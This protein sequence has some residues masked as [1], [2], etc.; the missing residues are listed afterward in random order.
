MRPWPVTSLALADTLVSEGRAMIEQLAPLGRQAASAILA[1]AAGRQLSEQETTQALQA[2]GG[3]P[4]LLTQSGASL[5]SSSGHLGWTG[6][7]A[8][9]LVSRFGGLSSS[10][11]HVTQAASVLG[12]RFRP[13]LVTKVA[14]VD[15]GEAEEA[16]VALVSAGLVLELDDG[17]AEFVHPLFAQALYDDVAEPTR[18][19]MHLLAMRAL[20][21][22]GADP[23]QAAT[24]ARAGHL[25][26]DPEAISVLEAAG[27]AALAV[28][29]VESALINLRAAVEMAGA[30]ATSSLLLTLAD[31][32]GGAGYAARAEGLCHR[33]LAA[34]P[35]APERVR[36]MTVLARAAFHSTRPDRA[37]RWFD[38]AADAAG[39]DPPELLNVL[40]EAVASCTAVSAPRRILPWVE[41]SRDVVD[42]HPCLDQGV[43]EAGWTLVAAMTGDPT[44]VESLLASLD[45]G[46]FEVAMAT[47]P[48]S[49]A[50]WM[51]I[52]VLNVAKLVERFEASELAFASGWDRAQRLGSPALITCVGISYADNL[53][54]LG[55]LE[56]ARGLIERVEDVNG[57]LAPGFFSVT[58]LARA[59]L[60][61][62]AGD[63]HAAEAACDLVDGEFLSDPSNHYPV[64]WIWVRKVRAELALDAGRV[65][66]A[67]ELA[68][69]MSDRAER[70][71]VVE[72]C[73]VPW[74]D[75]AVSAY[76]RA[77]RHDDAQALVDHLEA[78]STGWPCRWPRSVAE[79]GRAGLAEAR[80]DHDR[81]EEH[82]RRAIVLLDDVELPLARA[83][84]LADYGAF[85]RRNG[86]PT[87]ARVP[88]AQAVAWAQACDAT[89]LAGRASA[90]LRASGGRR[91]R[92]HSDDLSPQEQRVA[93]LAGRGATNAEI[94]ATLVVSVKTVEHHLG[95]IYSKLGIHSR[96]EL[97]TK[98]TGP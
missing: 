36:I 61:L 69:A 33:L 55:R 86:H 79:S 38:A 29:G 23:A 54:R 97:P 62:E 2:C 82:H 16:I 89:R 27:R 96:R 87:E 35:D 5:R 34:E 39:D 98:M 30:N 18:S 78:V 52:N 83:R 31:T 47:A 14:E 85:L 72:A 73:V 9:L 68:D 25:L 94:A 6:R 84:A 3:N 88:L 75:T 71:G 91:R 37:L 44:G 42:A 48:P 92:G 21:A 41:R 24:H 40:R 64:Q 67:A 11:L 90:D 58:A 59:D 4:F 51:A 1:E 95:T 12:T 80:N 43:I 10:A 7:E 26:G 70:A 49:L 66:D 76:L 63:P 28:G 13:S 93:D 65:D 32:E 20:V 74:A 50:I 77:G 56:Q 19:R 45:D 57:G 17:Q 46:T 22:V 53:C 8:R 60:A 15:R 81:A